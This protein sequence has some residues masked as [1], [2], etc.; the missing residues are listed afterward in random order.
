MKPNALV[1]LLVLLAA[2]DA[3]G[4]AFAEVP[5]DAAAER[6][7]AVR[8]ASLVLTEEE[9]VKVPGSFREFVG[10]RG[11]SGKEQEIRARLK[12]ELAALGAVEVPTS[13]DGPLNLV[14]ELPASPGLAEVPGVMLNAHID[15]VP[16]SDPGRME[17]EEA[18][19][20]FVHL[21]TG[22][23]G[24]TSS[25]GGDDRSS[26]AAIVSALHAVHARFW[27]KG[28][29]HRR[30]VV[31]FTAD[32][33][34]QLT[35]ARFIARD[36]PQVFADLEL[37]I[38]M[39]GPL[40][41]QSRYPEDSFVAVVA[42]ADE[43]KAPYDRVLRLISDYCRLSGRTFGRTEIGLGMGD[44]AAFPAAANAGLHLRSPVRGWHNNERVGVPDLV[45]HA[46][47]LAFLLLRLD[48]ASLPEA[49]SSPSARR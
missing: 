49:G 27:A 7:A 22:L 47:L 19:G 4:L 31:L 28:V 26:V 43:A 32:E 36:Q 3:R 29:P 14:M 42:G 6:T 17:F 48:H 46:D 2:P 18:S 38:A 45:S 30:I 11:P 35:G 33:E 13:R 40:D 37:A 1:L 15:T 10:I 12:T 25:F 21:D 8:S 34:R 44:F 5:A 20:D 9:R 39:D 23:P 41:L 16:H 24:K